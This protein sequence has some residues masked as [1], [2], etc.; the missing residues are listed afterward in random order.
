MTFPS[1]IE[2]QFSESDFFFEQT[3]RPSAGVI[4][5]GHIVGPMSREM[6]E[7]RVRPNIPYRPT[8]EEMVDAWKA[9]AH[10][11]SFSPQII[12]DDRSKVVPEAR[13]F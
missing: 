11:D 6:Y 10:L 12:K 2:T 8:Y 4:C 1:P 5:P 3:S 7:S 13:S 9:D